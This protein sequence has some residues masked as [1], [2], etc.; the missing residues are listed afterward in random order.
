MVVLDI[1]SA[2]KLRTRDSTTV[3]EYGSG[4]ES[5]VYERNGMV[6]KDT[7]SMAST[8]TRYSIFAVT[9][10]FNFSLSMFLIHL[11]RWEKDH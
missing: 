10:I 6:H 9:C 4:T 11:Q 7:N 2:W 5:F 3:K 1:R 8:N